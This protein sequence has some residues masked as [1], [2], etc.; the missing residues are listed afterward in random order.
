VKSNPVGVPGSDA[1]P[2]GAPGVA[3]RTDEAVVHTNP[4]EYQAGDSRDSTDKSERTDPL[5]GQTPLGQYRI[6]AKIGEGGFGA[7]YLA[8]Q[9][10]VDRKAVIKVLR[11]KAEGLGR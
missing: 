9:V 5:I 11:A 10:G 2:K 6:T 8:E 3:A 4:R 1:K 7:V